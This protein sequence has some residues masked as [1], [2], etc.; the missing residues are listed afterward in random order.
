[1]AL[2]SLLGE[3]LHHFVKIFFQTHSHYRFFENGLKNKN[4]KYSFYN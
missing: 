2:I 4:V 1:M 3:K